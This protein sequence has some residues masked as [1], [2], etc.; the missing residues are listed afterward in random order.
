MR[1]MLISEE[2]GRILEDTK[3]FLAIVP[4]GAGVKFIGGGDFSP[5]VEKL[6]PFLEAIVVGMMSGMKGL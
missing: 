2:D 3:T 5:L 4:S 6:R 1:K